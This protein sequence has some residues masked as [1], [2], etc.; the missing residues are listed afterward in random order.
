MFDPNQWAAK[1]NANAEEAERNSLM[2]S[3]WSGATADYCTRTHSLLLYELLCELQKVALLP[4]DFFDRPE[5]AA[6]LAAVAGIK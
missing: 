1:Y 3:G 6:V 2:D 5:L 4:A